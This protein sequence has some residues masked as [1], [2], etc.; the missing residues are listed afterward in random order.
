MNYQ[1]I[2]DAIIVNAKKY[3]NFRKNQKK[4]KLQ[5]FE[6]HHVIPKCLGGNNLKENLVLLTPKEHFICHKLLCK[7]F[8]ESGKLK[9]A[10][11]RMCTYTKL[12]DLHVSASSY[13]EAKNLVSEET[14]KMFKGKLKSASQ[15]EKIRETNSKQIP[16]NKGKTGLQKHSSE[17]RQR[18]RDSHSGKIMSAESKEKNKIK[19]LKENLSN[20][21]RMKMSNSAKR[22]W[23]VF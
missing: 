19:H 21:T 18:M 11:F 1:K 23:S 4:L 14:S 16:W 5:Y 13:S 3:A 10:Y 6:K 20:E 7:I 12:R 2:Y 17:V 15:I 9:Y 22:R 8:P